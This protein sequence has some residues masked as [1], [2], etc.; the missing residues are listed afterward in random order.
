MATI[1]RKVD[2]PAIVSR[3]IDHQ[4][5]PHFDVFHKGDVEVSKDTPAIKPGV[6]LVAPHGEW[7]KKRKYFSYDV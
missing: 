5:R 2:T 3:R 7:W 6:Y 1:L 4:G